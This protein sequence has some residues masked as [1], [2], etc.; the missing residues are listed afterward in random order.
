M[1]P[2]RERSERGQRTSESEMSEVAG[3]LG[4][5]GTQT[6]AQVQMVATAVGQQR[7]KAA[8]KAV[9]GLRYSLPMWG[10]TVM[11]C[12]IFDIQELSS[13]GFFSVTANAQNTAVTSIRLRGPGRPGAT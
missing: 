1:L 8:L 10:S 4:S 11:G 2:E 13:Q 3:K 7:L 12:F 6:P 5:A 9:F